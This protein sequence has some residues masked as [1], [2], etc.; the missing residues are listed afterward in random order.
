METVSRAILIIAADAYLMR[1]VPTQHDN[2]RLS[3]P[4]SDAPATHLLLSASA[5]ITGSAALMTDAHDVTDGA[6][7]RSGLYAHI[8]CIAGSAFTLERAARRARDV[9]TSSSSAG[10][11]DS[12]T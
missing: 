10:T 6:R 2:A 5:A 12:R 11:R 7:T 3:T 9:R 8:A 4:K 1:R